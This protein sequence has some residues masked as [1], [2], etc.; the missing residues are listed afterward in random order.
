ME[1]R[2]DISV[3]KYLVEITPPL[4]DIQRDGYSNISVK[5]YL[6]EITPPLHDIQRDGY[7][8]IS[9]KKYLVEIT[10]LKCQYKPN[11]INDIMFTNSFE[12]YHLE[13]AVSVEPIGET[14]TALKR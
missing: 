1:G 3:K 9:I 7:S 14:D 10:P 13:R 4:H 2:G 8:N 6:V 11:L 12:K 5:K